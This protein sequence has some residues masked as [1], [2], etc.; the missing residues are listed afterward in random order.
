[1]IESGNS[2]KAGLIIALETQDKDLFERKLKGTSLDLYKF[3][4]PGGFNIFHD[5]AKTILKEYMMI[6][7]L[8]ILLEE[9]RIRHP[10]FILTEM[11]NSL[12]VNDKQSP[13]HIAAKCNKIVKST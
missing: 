7:F 6:P 13:L 1:M 10:P 4:D 5:F 2:T 11:L 9:F 8:N 12:N 3:V